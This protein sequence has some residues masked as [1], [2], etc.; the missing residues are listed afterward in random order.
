MKAKLKAQQPPTFREWL[1]EGDLKYFGLVIRPAHGSLVSWV[2]HLERPPSWPAYGVT[3]FSRP[4][5]ICNKQVGT[6]RT[7]DL[8]L[9]NFA[10]LIKGKFLGN[11]PHAKPTIRVPKSFR[12]V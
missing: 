12:D 9:R 5:R 1:Q 11:S 2:C 7:P 3:V 10:H 8:A 4:K 6:G